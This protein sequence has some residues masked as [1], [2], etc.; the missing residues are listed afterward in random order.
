MNKRQYSEITIYILDKEHVS[1]AE[2]EMV[3]SMIQHLDNYRTKLP[4]AETPCNDD[5]LCTIC[6]A[7]PITAIFKPCNHTSCHSC[8]DRH[9]L[10]SRNCFFCKATIT[11][12]VT[13]EGKILHEFSS[14]SS[15]PDSMESEDSIQP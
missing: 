14:D 15:L 13:V 11:K 5:D 7:Y 2:I 8:I 6:Y 10:N 4:L 12:V 9:L 1:D 3:N